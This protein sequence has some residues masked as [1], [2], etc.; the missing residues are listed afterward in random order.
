M[1]ATPALRLVTCEVGAHQAP[2]ALRA[3]TVTVPHAFRVC[4]CPLVSFRCRYAMIEFA[5][6][7]EAEAAIKGMNG[8]KIMGRVVKVDWAFV[9]ADGRR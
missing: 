5:T 6:R 2:A 3:H 9:K 1:H 7:K 8:S 4:V